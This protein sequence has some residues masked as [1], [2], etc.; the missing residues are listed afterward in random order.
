MLWIYHLLPEHHVLLS[1]RLLRFRYLEVLMF[2]LLRIFFSG[3]LILYPS[4]LS[5]YLFKNQFISEDFPRHAVYYTSCTPLVHSDFSADCYK[6]AYE[7]TYT[8][9]IHFNIKCYILKYN[10]SMVDTMYMHIYIDIYAYIVNVFCVYICIY[11]NINCFFVLKS[12]FCDCRYLNIH[13]ITEYKC[14]N[15]LHTY[16]HKYTSE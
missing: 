13:L 4:V 7:D 2:S 1:P 16:I 3:I 12:Q 14:L 6:F 5:M 10:N 11:T 8:L 15:V 9:D